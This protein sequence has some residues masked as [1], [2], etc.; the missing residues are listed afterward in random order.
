MCVHMLTCLCGGICTCVCMLVGI[1]IH[2]CGHAC[3][4]VYAHV[5]ACLCGGIYTCVHA[6]VGVYTHVC[7]CL[8]VRY[9]HMSVHA[10]VG[11][12]ADVCVHRGQRPMS[13][14]FLCCSPHHTFEIKS[15]PELKVH[16]FG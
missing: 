11:V 4:G 7:A 5:C 1:Y 9:M 16:H 3:A 10:C 8:C 14:V 13:D 15:L 12:C 2:M 6:C